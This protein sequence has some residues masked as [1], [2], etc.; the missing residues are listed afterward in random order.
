MEV[1][2]EDVIIDNLIIDILILLT[3][4]NMAKLNSKKWRLTLSSVFGTAI[5]LFSPL[6]PN[7]ANILIKPFVAASM[8]LIAFDTK[9]LKKFLA[10]YLLFFLATFAYG[11][12]SIGICELFGIEYQ[13]SSNLSYQ[14]QVPIGVILLVCMVI[15]FCLKNAIKLCFNSH[16]LDKYKFEITIQN[17]GKNI[18]I[19]YGTIRMV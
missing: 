6:L 12:A 7:F 10:I 13:I 4:K 9:N 5:A 11:G 8:V 16:R 3:V 1:W 17:N 18:T 19:I 14:N 2:V 15:Y